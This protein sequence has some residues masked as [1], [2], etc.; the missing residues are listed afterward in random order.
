MLLSFPLFPL[1]LRS[2]SKAIP[3]EQ[4]CEAF[5]YLIHR[6][7]ETPGLAAAD[8]HQRLPAEQR[9]HLDRRDCSE[10]N[11]DNPEETQFAAE[12]KSFRDAFVEKCKAED[13]NKAPGSA[14]GGD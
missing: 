1:A 12:M 6:F 3:S 4:R 8:F 9:L 13:A 14:F 10:E 11:I 2:P 7:L 5:L